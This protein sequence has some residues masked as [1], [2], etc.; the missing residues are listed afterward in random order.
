MTLHDVAA[1]VDRSLAEVRRT[2]ADLGTQLRALR[3]IGFFGPAHLAEMSQQLEPVARR[4]LTAPAGAVA[5][6]GVAWESTDPTDRTGMLWWRADGGAVTQKIH[7]DNPASD[8]YYDFTHSEWYTRA[9][10]TDELVIAGPFIDAWGT[11]DHTLTP[12]IAVRDERGVRL[13]VAAAD[14]D[15][16]ATTER[17]S[18]VLAAAPGELILANDE[19]HVVVANDPILTPGL[20]LDPFLARQRMRVVERAVV[21]VHGWELLRLDA[22]L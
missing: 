1:D 11:D 13:G 19:G 5:G 14:L 9:I 21:P 22:D 10:G 6:A 15:V 2:L 18:R 8:S 17:I 7:V 20:R 3:E 4:A 12:A 16:G